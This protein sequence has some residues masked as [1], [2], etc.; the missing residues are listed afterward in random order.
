MSTTDLQTRL[1][2][3]TAA[4]DSG[5]RTVTTSDGAFVT[6]RTLEEMREVQRGLQAQLAP[7]GVRTRP[8]VI[9]ASFGTLRGG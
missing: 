3:I 7:A 6:Y 5:E 2:R 8:L 1:A 9:R 4:I